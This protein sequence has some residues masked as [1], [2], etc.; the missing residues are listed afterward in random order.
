M[1]KKFNNNKS[2]LLLTIPGLICVFIWGYVPLYGAIIA[3]K[4]FQYNL[5][6]LGSPWVG[7]KNFEFFFQSP[8]L[9]RITR[10]TVGYAILFLGLK[11]ICGMSIALLLFEIRNKSAL[12]Y[13]QTTMLLPNFLSWVIVGFISYIM[14]NPSLGILN[15]FLGSIGLKSVDWYSERAYWPFIIS[16]FQVWKNIGMDCILYYA[17]LT[18]VD[19][20]L[21]EAAT[22]DGANKWQQTIKITIPMLLSITFIMVILGMGN[23]FRGDFG[24]FY[25]I[26]R[27]IGTLYPVTDV[28]DTYVFRGLQKGSMSMT[29]AIGLFQ[30]FVGFVFIVGANLLV[31]KIDSDKSL[32]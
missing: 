32:F 29:S 30:S 15:Q 4:D 11:V 31:K 6:I 3:F 24:L 2:L 8:D 18:G 17:A 26:P 22:V 5:G 16:F 19:A 13:Y 1:I 23:I 20:S 21:F 27:D 28:I 10:N 12:K 14:L 7:F 25:Q 9:W